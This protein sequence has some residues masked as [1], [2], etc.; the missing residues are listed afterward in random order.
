MVKDGDA[1]LDA[2]A[3]QIAEMVRLR[4]AARSV[5]EEGC[6]AARGPT[7]MREGCSGCPGEDACAPRA[8]A[9]AGASRIGIRPDDIRSSRELAQFIDH[10]LLRPDATYEDLRKLCEE[11]K[12]YGFA[13]VCVNSSNVGSATR[14]LEGSPVKA[15]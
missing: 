13:T 15:I 10:T 8:L 4:L 1:N 9:S 11:A 5:G 2:L 14:L 12:R 3:D 6:G 7:E